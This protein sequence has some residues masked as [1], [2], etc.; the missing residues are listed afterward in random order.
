MDIIGHGFLAQHLASMAGSHDRVVV[1]A[2]GVSAAAA[3]TPE[4]FG[5]ETD[6][7]ASVLDRCLASGERLLFFSTASTGIYGAA[8]RGSEDE[9]SVPCTPYGQHKLRLER[10]IQASGADYLIVRLAHVA[11]PS[12]PGHQLLP[13]LLDQVNAGEVT[14]HE[15]AR[16]D[17]IDVADVVTIID[18][19]LGAGVSRDVV[20][21]ATGWPVPVGDLVSWIERETGRRAH[22]TVLRRPPVNHHIS[23]AKLRRLVPEVEQMGFGAD[24]Y[25]SVLGRY[26]FA[27]ALG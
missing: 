12:Q 26:L 7:V 16:R 24:Y 3:T 22:R 25:T 18:H 11:G 21:I 20:N 23:T 13:S 1:L 2:A 17:I 27:A 14:L 15:G 6:L 10:L 9:D 4:Q 5:R 19:L 8:Q